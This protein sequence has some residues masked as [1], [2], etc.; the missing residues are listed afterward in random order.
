MP[1]YVCFASVDRLTPGQK[2][3]IAKAITQVHSEEA[4]APRYL[5]QVVFQSLL[6]TQHFV[7]GE[8]GPQGQI[9]IRGDIR[10]GRTEAQRTRLQLRL[11][12]EVGTI[13]GSSPDDLWIYLNEMQPSNMMEFGHLLP[14]PGDE[15]KWFLTLPEALRDR[16]GKY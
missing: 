14:G 1:T 15:G 8:P 11:A 2:E 3:K 13:A 6:P 9:W 16:L 5:V 4:V 10:A 7:G 12:K